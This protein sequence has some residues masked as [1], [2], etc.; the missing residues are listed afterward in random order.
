LPPENVLNGFVYGQLAALALVVL[1][2]ATIAMLMWTRSLGAGGAVPSSS[3][4]WFALPVAAAIAG[5]VVIG[6]AVNRRISRALSQSGRA[7][8]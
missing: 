8:T 5:T 3:F 1:S 2:T 4:G 6:A 7:R